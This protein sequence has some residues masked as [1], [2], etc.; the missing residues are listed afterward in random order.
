M[1]VVDQGPGLGSGVVTYVGE[2]VDEKTRTVPL[3]VTVKNVVIGASGATA[4]LRPGMFGTLE[5]EIARR[6]AVLTIPLA[7]VQTVNGDPT[8]FVLVDK[9]QEEEHDHEHGEKKGDHDHDSKPAE[10]PA[11]VYEP[12]KL[13]LGARTEDRIEVL[14]G[15]KAGEKVAVENAYLL[16]SEL[17]KSRISEGH[18]H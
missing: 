3:R 1:R 13:A 6:E 12:R 8:A 16:K 9:P 18:A 14:K 15:L 17:E 5:I 10:R 11:A 2:R 4:M 7:A